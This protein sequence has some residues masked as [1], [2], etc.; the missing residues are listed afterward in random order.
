MTLDEAARL[1]RIERE[2][3]A[4]IELKRSMAAD[5]RWLL[6]TVRELDAMLAA[7][8]ANVESLRIEVLA[9]EGK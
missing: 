7:E 8:R 6:R 2:L 1:M 3:D 4:S 5:I 9:R